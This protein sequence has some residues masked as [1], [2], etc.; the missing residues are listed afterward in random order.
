MSK[1]GPKLLFLRSRTE[2]AAASSPFPPTPAE[3]PGWALVQRT[4]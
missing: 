1:V 3:G 2:A 4:E